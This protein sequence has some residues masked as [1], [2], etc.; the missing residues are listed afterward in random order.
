MLLI[1][2]TCTGIYIRY[3]N[4]SRSSY[5]RSVFAYTRAA[6]DYID[7]DRISHYLET[8]E[9]DEYYFTILDWLNASQKESDLKYYYVY[10]PLKDKF[11]GTVDVK[12]K[13]I[14]LMHLWILE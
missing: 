14:Q 2:F 4:D 13:I 5:T 10:V 8:G 6:A 9:K 12:N 3:Y 11:I 1:V 7:G